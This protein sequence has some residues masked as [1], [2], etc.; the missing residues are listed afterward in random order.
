MQL[1]KTLVG[2]IIGALIGIAIM[3]AVYF[4]LKFDSVWL[5]LPVAVLTGLGV[6]MMVSTSG[7][8]SY[9][10][11]ALTGALALGA[12]LVGSNVV[13]VLAQ[14]SAAK[15]AEATRIDAPADAKAADAK[16]DAEADGQSEDD[17]ANEVKAAPATP[18][19]PRQ[20][21]REANRAPVQTSLPALDFIVMCASALFAYE[22]GRGTAPKSAVVTSD[23][24][25]PADVPQGTH[26]DA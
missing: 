12:Y 25:P 3:V 15:A 26:P 4:A 13:M 2:A 7:H 22:L 9:L 8:A 20:A 24:A 10:R 1:G 16:D 21:A 18:P 5:A 14:Q 11:G 6:R 23:D 17:Q 19:R